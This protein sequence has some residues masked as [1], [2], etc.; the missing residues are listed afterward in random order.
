MIGHIR[1]KGGSAIAKYVSTEFEFLG[2][3]TQ[4]IVPKNGLYKLEVW[5]AQGGNTY[6]NATY[7]A[8]GGLG[9]YACGYKKFKKGDL[10][11][12]AVGGQPQGVGNP[13]PGYNGGGEG[14]YHEMYDIGAGGGGA[15]HIALSDGTLK[16]IGYDE[17]V[18]NAKGLIVAGG[19]GG[20]HTEY[21]HW[22]DGGEYKSKENG[23]AGGGANGIDLRN[24]YK[25]GSQTS[26]GKN[27]GFG[28][29]GGYDTGGYKSWGAAGGGGGFYGGAGN[30]GQWCAAA[31]GSGWIDGVQTVLYKN[32]EYMPS[33]ETGVN[34]G[35]GKATITY[36][37]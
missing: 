7:N 36:I 26:A 21:Q 1:D 35:N 12:V 5:G 16:E 18:T 17:F 8:T 15:S 4:F 6:R 14:V 9:G 19:G 3:T 34:E 11:Y 25:G 31:G 30:I 23:T 24:V 2:T 27:G 13:A 10:L 37:G 32:V 20:S 28:Y 22:D 33:M 29:G